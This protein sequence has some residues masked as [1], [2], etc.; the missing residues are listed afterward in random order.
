MVEY[1]RTDISEGN[2][3]NKTNQSNEC[4]IFHYCYFLG[5]GFEP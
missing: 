1:N 3:V 5:K 4:N 2:D